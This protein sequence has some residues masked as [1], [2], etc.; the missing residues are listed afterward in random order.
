[1][2]M[3]RRIFV[4]CV[5]SCASS[6]CAEATHSPSTTE[7]API[8]KEAVILALKTDRQTEFCVVG[9]RETQNSLGYQKLRGISQTWTT[10]EDFG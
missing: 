10:A 3:D 2:S 8:S 4:F 6:G 1:M 5:F 9:S 7:N